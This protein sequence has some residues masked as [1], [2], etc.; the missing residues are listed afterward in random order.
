MEVRTYL[1]I[2]WLRSPFYSDNF[3][4]LEFLT[5]VDYLVTQNCI[6]AII[7]IPFRTAQFIISS[8]HILKS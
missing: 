6:L 4:S 5:K 1:P 8:S 2:H 7:L 3:T